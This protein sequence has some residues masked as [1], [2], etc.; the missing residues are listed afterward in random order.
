MT[1][2]HQDCWNGGRVWFQERVT[3]TPPNCLASAKNSP[4]SVDGGRGESLAAA[5]FHQSLLCQAIFLREFIADALVL[6]R[7]PAAFRCMVSEV[8]CD[9]A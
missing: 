5:T 2:K 4:A 7:P 1:Q 8:L 9:R 3:N 6:E